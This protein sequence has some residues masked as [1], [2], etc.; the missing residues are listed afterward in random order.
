ML[1]HPRGRVLPRFHCPVQVK[2][3]V[4][5]RRIELLHEQLHGEHPLGAH[6]FEIVIVV[7]H[8]HIVCARPFTC[9]VEGVSESAPRVE[10]LTNLRPY[11]R[12]NHPLVPELLRGGE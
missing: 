11:P 8:A 12:H 4:H 1:G 5:E 6:E 3:E 2:L 7:P 10:R 9:R